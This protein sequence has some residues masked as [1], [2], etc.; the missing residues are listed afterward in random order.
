MVSKSGRKYD[1]N[2]LNEIPAKI[3]LKGNNLYVSGASQVGPNKWE[4]ATLMY[5]T[6][7]GT[8]L[9]E[10][11]SV[12]NATQG[13][14]EINDLTIDDNGDIYITGAVNN[15]NSFDIAI[16]KL[17]ENLNILWEKHYDGYGNDDK[18]NGIKVDSQGNVYVAGTVETNNEGKNYIL[19]KYSQN[20]DL[21]WSRE[22]NGKENTDDEAT[23]LVISNNK[24]FVTGLAKNSSLTSFQTLVYNEDG[25]IYTQAEFTNP[26]QN[27]MPTGI[28]VDLSGNII[29]IGQTDLG[30]GNY[31]ARTVKYTLYEKPFEPVFENGEPKYNANEVIIR[32]DRSAIKYDAIDRKGFTAG[33]LGDF[34]KPNVIS[35]MSS[36]LGFDVSRLETF[37]IHRGM[38]TAD[39]LSITRLGDTIQVPDFWASLTV[40]L[41]EKID[42]LKVVDSLNTI[43]FNM[44][45]Y[46]ELNGIIQHT[47]IPNDSL[48]TIE[49]A[50]LIPTSQYPDAHIN[51]NPAWDIETGYWNVKVGVFDDPIY[52][53]HED[54][55]DGT[56]LGSKITDGWDFYNNV[57]VSTVLSPGSSHGTSVA[58][59]IGAYRNN[60]IGIAGIAGGDG[61]N[62]GVQLI[63]M[64]IFSSG[65]FSTN[66]K[67]KEAI[68]K[69]SLSTTN[70][71]GY[72]INI[73]N[74]SWGGT[75]QSQEIKEGVNTAW[76]NH[77]IF[78]AS[79]GNDGSNGNPIE[80]PACYDDKKVLNVGA[81]G[82][83]GKYKDGTNGDILIGQQTNVFWSSSYGNGVDFIAPGCTELVTTPYNPISPY[84]WQNTS[85]T[86]NNYYTFNG[87]SAAAPHVAGVT[88]L[89]YS[90]H[91]LDKGAP[92]NLATED[93]EHI[94]E[95]TAN[96][97]QNPGSYDQKNGHGLI[98]AYD[99]AEEVNFPKYIIK[100]SENVTPSQTTSSGMNIILANNVNG[101][102][103]G[104]YK[105]DR[106]QVNWTYIDVLPT[107]QE[108]I[109]WWPLEARTIKGVS[110]VVP[111][112]GEEWMDITPNVTI[113]GNVAVFSVQTFAWWVKKSNVSG[114]DINKWIP[115]GG[116]SNM[117]FAYSL[118][119]KDNSVTSL[120]ENAFENNVI[121][122]PN[123]T[124][125]I[126]NV[127][128]EFQNSSNTTLFIY[129]TQG[130]LIANPNLGIKNK[131]EQNFTINISNLPKGMY[132]LKIV[133]ENNSITKKFIKE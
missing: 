104:A 2:G 67:A 9:G 99:A 21:L 110:A 88:A 79:R 102:A 91:H 5:K 133:S 64:G 8:L 125:E 103:A 28:T 65:D 120:S 13:V 119:I 130:K 54:F 115:N 108:I 122:Y 94:L 66:A 128:L 25:S 26:D 111:V 43:S 17:D 126:L 116:P 77:S 97:K 72:G 84:W 59:I 98:N 100:H 22:F 118:H 61:I 32:F 85:S 35:E 56:F 71:Y 62:P 69:G 45:H 127:S 58:G 39:S 34:V 49:Q 51:I 92:N 57:H 117:R 33:M 132:L 89:M 52:W 60:G 81:S 129:D 44:V 124:N 68:V 50:G 96:N 73:Q 37:K 87:T 46:A 36:K 12:G 30:N 40:R 82:I 90:K 19:L 38:T 121:I 55:G 7:D 109:D 27:E 14:N 4:L 70:N 95:K 74:H 63:S 18:G 114:Q 107:Y 76:R 75:Q 6:S 10:R 112:T 11:R 41:P 15:Q 106:I 29:V 93:V 131:G 48:V 16:Y 3:E 31:R 47:S 42:E 20:G 101:I 78:I 113:G 83:D 80:Y 1:F 53:V 23:Q 123:P 86:P 105:A 24:I